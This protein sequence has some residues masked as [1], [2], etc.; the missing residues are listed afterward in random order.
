MEKMFEI[1]D[2]VIKITGSIH[3]ENHEP[4][5]D[6][7]CKRKT[8]DMFFWGLADGQSG[9]EHCVLGGR[10]VLGAIVEYISEKGITSLSQRIYTDEI[11]YELIQVIR[12]QI[13]ALTETYRADRREFSSTLVICAINPRTGEYMTVHLGDGCIVAVTKE[14]AVSMISMPD[15]GITGG[16]TWL[17]TSENALMHL[18]ICYG[19]IEKIKCFYLMSDGMDCICHGKNILHQ[20][21]ELLKQGNLRS[22]QKYVTENRPIDD[23]TC[24]VLKNVG[25]VTV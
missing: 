11:R 14:S 17:T 1:S 19:N 25:D 12:K 20:G 7:V 22:L 15:N 21:M 5:E 3:N 4:M 6:V 2:T 24:I 18:R 16:Y 13:D 9:K 23:A 10:A 8:D